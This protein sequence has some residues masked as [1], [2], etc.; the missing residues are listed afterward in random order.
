MSLHVHPLGQT[1]GGGGAEFVVCSESAV[2]WLAALE[3]VEVTATPEEM[4]R[5]EALLP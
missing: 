1:V 3:L 4:T 2:T 5:L